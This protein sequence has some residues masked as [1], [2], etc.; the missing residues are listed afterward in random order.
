M[1]DAEQLKGLNVQISILEQ[2]L[3]EILLRT[4]NQTQKQKQAERNYDVVESQKPSFFWLRKIFNRSTVNE[5]FERLNSANEMLNNLSEQTSELLNNQSKTKQDLKRNTDQKN[6]VNQQQKKDKSTLDQW[7]KKQQSD[8]EH[9]H[10]K[11][12]S[13]EKIKTQS[14][15]KELDFSILKQRCISKILIEY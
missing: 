15:I 5:Y 10:K 6:A 13:L 3:S 4:E 12:K 8:L 11:I 14:G 2:E 7:I 1:K 9:L